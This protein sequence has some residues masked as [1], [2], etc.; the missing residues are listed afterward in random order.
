MLSIADKRANADTS[1]RKKPRGSS[2]TVLISRGQQF[3]ILKNNRKEKGRDNQGLLPHG[4]TLGKEVILLSVIELFS[5]F[6]R[7][8]HLRAFEH[9]GTRH[10][11]GYGTEFRPPNGTNPF[12]ERFRSKHSA[13]PFRRNAKRS[14]PKFM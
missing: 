9:T 6:V 5:R 4:K 7:R 12:P 8:F 3:N 1:G 14:S 11:C 10:L 2:C 13:F